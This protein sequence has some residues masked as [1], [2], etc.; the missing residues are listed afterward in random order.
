MNK[1]EYTPFNFRDSTVI[2]TLEESLKKHDLWNKK[3]IIGVSGGVDSMALLT[4]LYE[5]KQQLFII[6]IN[7]K[8]RGD[9][10]EKDQELVEHIA[11]FYSYEVAS[12]K[13]QYLPEFG[14][15]QA[16][17]RQIRYQIFSELRIEEK[18]AAIVL[19]HHREDI[20]ETVF[21]KLFR[22]ASPVHWDGIKM[23]EEE[24]ARFRPW[25]KHSKLELIRYALNRAVPYR[26]DLTN[27]E[28]EYNRNWL[29]NEWVPMLNQR[30]PGW[31]KHLLDLSYY[32]QLLQSYQEHWATRF[33]QVNEET[34]QHKVD[35]TELKP[36]PKRAQQDRLKVFIQRHPFF[37]KEEG[38]SHGQ[39]IQLRK[40]IN[41]EP[42]K[43][44]CVNDRMNVYRQRDCLLAMPSRI[45][46]QQTQII[47]QPRNNELLQKEP[48][49]FQLREGINSLELAKKGPDLY[50][51][52]Q[53]ISWPLRIREWKEGDRFTPLGMKGRKKMSDYL[54]NQ[55]IPMI[56]KSD[57]KILEDGNNSIIA[58]L[59]P[60]NKSKD[61]SHCGIPANR[62]K[63]TQ[64]TK[65]VLQ[66]G[67]K[68]STC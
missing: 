68:S 24:S 57:Y 19:A 43:K 41:A 42:G 64:A 13:V 33:I 56:E 5:L 37:R 23:W 51:D 30:F 44:V 50:L 65:L 61:T 4:A 59:F 17:A 1:L 58:V 9:N 14:N 7:Y 28:S 55:K 18:A 10:S 25:L 38:L 2:K 32:G 63:C 8:L 31:D 29:R 66:I 54:I 46:P 21:L 40:L 49:Q 45:S 47:E 48:Y 22:G 11:Q 12:F 27:S 60:S 6:H 67:L 53:T 52:A 26:E 39:L 15:F 35:L 3:L 36:Y 16:W 34:N 62:Q 20:L